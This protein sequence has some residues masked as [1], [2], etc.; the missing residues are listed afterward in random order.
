MKADG[1]CVHCGLKSP[2]VVDELCCRSV[3]ATLVPRLRSHQP[4]EYHESEDIDSRLNTVSYPLPA[5]SHAI[6]F[7]T[8]RTRY[9]SQAGVPLAPLDHRRQTPPSSILSAQHV[10]QDTFTDEVL[11]LPRQNVGE[12]MRYFTS[13]EVQTVLASW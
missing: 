11:S 10:A 6:L 4:D 3:D 8:H 13:R 2:L 9:L 5:G 1:C 7:A 12:S